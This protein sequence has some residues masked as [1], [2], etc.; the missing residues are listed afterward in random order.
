MDYATAFSMLIDREGGYHD[1]RGDPG[2]ETKFGISKR[3]YPH[4][5]IR[6]L[7][8]DDAWQIYWRD[9]WSVI[10]ADDLPPW[11]RF[12][13]F[14]AAVNSGPREAVRW[15]QQ[16]LGVADDGIIGPVTLNAL[17]PAQQHATLMVMI[18]VRLMFMTKL[19]NWDEA[20]RGWARRIA[21]NLARAGRTS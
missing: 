14:D 21:K 6:D 2:G 12:D 7:T 10:R 9:F 19:K 16:A 4:L 17:R 3:S 8:I 15:L 20:G 1:G 11:V 13:L 5:N 18:G